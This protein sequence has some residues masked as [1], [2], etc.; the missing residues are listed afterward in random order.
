MWHHRNLT[1]KLCSFLLFL[2][3]NAFFATAQVAVS[4]QSNDSDVYN[5][6]PGTG[7]LIFYVYSEKSGVRLDR[8]ALIKLTRAS[9][10]SATWQT[11]DLSSRSVFANLPVG[12][13]AA[14]ISAVG[15]FN[16]R[17]TLSVAAALA[18]RLEIILHRDPAAVN[19]DVAK[20]ILSPKARKQAKKGISSLKANDSTA[21]R[22][23]LEAAYKL[24]PSSTEINFLL[25][26][27]HFQTKD[28]ARAETYLAA[29]SSLDSRNAQALILLG[30]TR[31]ERQQYSDATP[32]LE[33]AILVDSANWLP[34]NLLATAYFREKD[35]DKAC[36][37]ARLAIDKAN[38]SRVGSVASAQLVL[39]ESLVGL[40]RD[41]EG[42]Q[43]LK[44]FLEQAP[45]HPMTGQVRALLIELEARPRASSDSSS[46]ASQPQITVVDPLAAIPDP[47]I[48]ADIWHIPNVDEVKPLLATGIECSSE[49]V[50][51]ETGKRVKELVEDLT[52]FAAVEDLFHQ[53]LDSAGLPL[54]S[55]IRKYD[56]VALLSES[57]PGTVTVAESRSTR[58]SRMADN[59]DHISSTGFAG[60]AL[61]FHPDMRKD[62]DLT[63][64]G[65][66]E[67]QG[68]PTWLVRFRQRSDR[69]N[70]MHSYQ[71]GSQIFPADLKGIAWIAADTFQIVRIEADLIKPIPEL[72]LLAEHQSVDYGPV[73]FPR[74]SITLWLPKQAEIY[75]KF[76]KRNYFRRHSFD[77]YMLF[78]V[79]TEEKRKPPSEP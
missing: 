27:L 39:G 3:L 7:V 59:P 5:T 24:A 61:V 19:L 31:L 2:F 22:R 79:D 54:N 10:Q 55:E 35:Y 30:R 15:Y 4:S 60:L 65:L 16:I 73:P 66:A 50:I 44:L 36:S 11:T 75:F 12:D 40:G 14:E 32:I 41:E 63:C 25:G 20:T 77:H 13:Y 38:Q 18:P 70:R 34:H 62:F 57:A 74:K 42:M 49:T 47:S 43:A 46:S 69:P 67:W 68:K 37:E 48:S 17:Q 76:R 26:Y 1:R 64:D 52:R 58:L 53:S 21:A 28:F 6:A 72:Q 29:A 71:I 78:S 56:Y 33:Q 9:D 23:Q 51:T 45:H 8:Q